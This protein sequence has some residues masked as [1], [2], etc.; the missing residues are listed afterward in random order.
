[1]KETIYEI[2]REAALFYY[3][4]LKKKSCEE[5][6]NYLMID[7]GLKAHIVKKFGIGYSL[8]EWDRLYIYMTRKGYSKELLLKSGLVLE[9]KKGNCYDRF[10]NR[11]M[12][13]ILDIK[14]KVI[15]FGGR[16]IDSSLPKY[17]NSPETIVY[18]KKKNLYNLNY[19]SDVVMEMIL[20]EGYMDVVSLFQNGIKNV[21]ASLGTAL[22]EEQARLLKRYSMSVVIAYDADAAGRSA[23]IKAS[24]VLKMY[25]LDT[26]ILN[27]P[28]NK[29]PD[30]YV[31]MNGVDKFNKLIERSECIENVT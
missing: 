11:I 25:Q 3:Q 20:V 26:K 14:G 17:M 24:N 28:S 13:P 19:A 22:T 1:M 16:N 2:N 31:R 27:M 23:A 5:A 30:E 9:N 7:R 8:N 12:F 18:N 6:S 21:V 10:R 29:D 15:G 4:N